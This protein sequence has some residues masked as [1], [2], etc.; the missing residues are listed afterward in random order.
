M[1]A[2]SVE[3]FK[4]YDYRSTLPCHG[5]W[6]R[7]PETAGPGRG[8]PPGVRVTPAVG[9]PSHGDLRV[10]VNLKPRPKQMRSRDTHVFGNACDAVTTRRLP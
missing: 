5:D 1:I 6:Q 7:H 9:I 2:A 8:A 4:Y 3:L 10:R